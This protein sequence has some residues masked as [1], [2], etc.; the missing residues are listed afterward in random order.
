MVKK[1]ETEMPNKLKILFFGLGSIGRRHARLIK[2]NFDF[3]LYAYRSGKGQGINDLGIK[4]FYDLEEAFSIKPDVAFITNPTYLHTS[5]AME[6]AK[7][8]IALFIE[9]PLSNNKEGLSDLLKV[10]KKNNIVTYTAYCLRFHLAIIWLKN[11]LKKH[12][13]L[14][15]TVFN[16]SY[17]PNWR[18]NVDHL[19]HYN[20]FKE[21]G[22]G[23]I[24]E[25]SHDIDY[26]YY[27][28]GDVKKISVNSGKISDVTIDSED[29]VDVILQFE[30]N[31]FGNMYVNFLSRQLRI[32]VT[33]DFKDS[34]IIADIVKNTI[35][36]IKDKKQETIDFNVERDDYFL[37]QLNYFFSHF[38]QGKLMNDLTESMKVFDIIMRIKKEAEIK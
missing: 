29:F 27:L 19:K 25:L 11:Y 16:S 26:L 5:T 1:M 14:H 10:V 2:D 17:L 35:M 23:V 15:I 18:E 12:T 34:T 4:E 30:N 24:L 3:E 36:I 28:F 20:A 38:R 31:V 32:D 7:R 9:K 37:S 21:K 6:C 8:N 13:P 33:V 22:G